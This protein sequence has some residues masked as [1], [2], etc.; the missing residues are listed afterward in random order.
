[1]GK[2]DERQLY[3]LIVKSIPPD[4]SRDFHNALMDFGSLVCTRNDPSCSACPL[5]N[6]CQFYPLYGR[7]KE[8]ALFVMEKKTE[9]GVI[10]NGRHVPN[11]IFRGRIVEF[12]R[13]NDGDL[14]NLTD[15]GKVVKSDYDQNDREWLLSLCLKLQDEE[16]IKYKVINERIKLE[17]HN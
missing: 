11:R 6:S 12:V 7:Q 2:E 4:R 10:E 5:Q 8:K 14:I 9:K 15:L 16:L 1:M 13:K 17:L 3:G